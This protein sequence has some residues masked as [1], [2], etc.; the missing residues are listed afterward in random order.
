MAARSVWGEFK[1]RVMESRNRTYCWSLRH[2][3]SGGSTETPL[4]QARRSDRDLRAGQMNQ[5][6]PW[7]L[8]RSVS[9]PP[10][11]ARKGDTGVRTP[12]RTERATAICASEKAE[13]RRVSSSERNERGEKESGSL[14]NLIVAKESRRTKLREPVSS[15]GGCLKSGP[16]TGNHGL[17]PES[18]AASPQRWWIAVNGE[19]AF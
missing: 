10:R 19:A 13:Q 5:R 15:E 18:A 2:R 7:E 1:S 12:R 9:L 8:V 17:N 14:N 16:A 4:S 11:R 6:V 3:P